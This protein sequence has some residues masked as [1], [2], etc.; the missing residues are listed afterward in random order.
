MMN[1]K[2]PT[3]NLV[4]NDAERRSREMLNISIFKTLSGERYKRKK[5]NEFKAFGVALAGLILDSLAFVLIMVFGTKALLWAL[6]PIID[7]DKFNIHSF[8]DEVIGTLS[9]GFAPLILCLALALML[10]RSKD[11][12]IKDR[13]KNLAS[14][15]HGVVASI[16]GFKLVQAYMYG[17]ANSSEDGVIVLGGISL[18]IYAIFNAIDS[19][20]IRK[21]RG[22]Q[23]S[24]YTLFVVITV[25]WLVK[26]SV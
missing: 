1:S 13:L 14:S 25:L 10:M 26:C 11:D 5:Y 18:L 8:F 2:K 6:S 4:I 19:S 17:T 15:L 22:S 21:E 7:K 23:I 16:V 20:E 12:F 9:L 3:I 24:G